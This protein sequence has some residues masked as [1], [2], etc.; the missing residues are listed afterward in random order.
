MESDG[1]LDAFCAL[2]LYMFSWVNRIVLYIFL[3]NSFKCIKILNVRFK[4]GCKLLTLPVLPCTG[5]HL[6]TALGNMIIGI[7]WQSKCFQTFQETRSSPN[8]LNRNGGS[9][10]AFAGVQSAKAK[11][12]HA[13]ILFWTIAPFIVFKMLIHITD[14]ALTYYHCKLDLS[15]LYEKLPS[16]NNLS[17]LCI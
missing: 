7:F 4:G 15:Y 3:A 11:V 10:L 13:A 17:I 1:K 9:M 8:F 2:T 5:L 16:K 6:L 12:S 14:I